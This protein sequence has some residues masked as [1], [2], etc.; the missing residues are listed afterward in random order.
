[1]LPATLSAALFGPHTTTPLGAAT[2]SH[3]GAYHAAAS[4]C[5]AAIGASAAPAT[6]EQAT[7]EQATDRLPC[8]VDA[9]FA[10]SALTSA[11]S[12]SAASA[13]DTRQHRPYFGCRAHGGKA[14]G[15][16]C[17]AQGEAIGS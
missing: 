16:C 10:T 7:A 1:M 8:A 14:I 3:K 13:Y 6:T 2:L 11:A 15:S 4:Y 17:G 5:G 9:T 12:A